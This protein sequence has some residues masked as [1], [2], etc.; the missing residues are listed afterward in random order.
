MPGLQG[1]KD[2]AMEKWRRQSDDKDVGVVLASGIRSR[3][4]VAF[5]GSHVFKEG[6]ISRIIAARRAAA[7]RSG[8]AQPSDLYDATL[9][10][11]EDSKHLVGLW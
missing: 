10:G 3:G 11:L 5:G 7:M 1:A 2:T 8:L 9:D 6:I 4:W